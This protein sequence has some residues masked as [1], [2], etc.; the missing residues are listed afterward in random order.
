MIQKEILKQVIEFY[1]KKTIKKDL[2]KRDVKINLNLDLITIISGI[3]R[4]GKSTLLQTELKTIKNLIYLN[5]EDPRLNKFTIE[6]FMK[7]EELFPNTNTYFFDE[8]Q[9]IENW[10]QYIRFA[11]DSNK[12]IFLTGSNASMLSRELGTKLTGRYKNIELF[13]FN[14]N[15]F[16]KIKKTKPSIDS[17]KEFLIKGG[18]PEFLKTDDIEYLQTLFNNILSRDIIV[19]RDIKNDKQIKELALFLLSNVGKEFSFNKTSKLLGIKSVRTIIDYTNY[20]KESYLIELIPN[21]SPS[22]KKQIINPKKAYAIDLGMINANTLSLSD[23]SGRKL[24]NVI[25][26]HLRQKYKKIFYFKEE[27]ECDF[28]CEDKA[29]QVCLKLNEDNLNREMNGLKEALKK[30][31]AKEGII[32]TLNQEDNLNKIK[33]IPAWK[34]LLN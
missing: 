32:I 28:I 29:F 21:Y 8:I 10:E 20:L 16:L 30:T 17:F 5:F 27:N 13:P 6:D 19:R 2:I 22:I 1:K 15:E 14:Y 18:F 3:R 34:F 7:I 12:R 24:E 33:V 11:H 4:C 9:N 23:D 25:Y 26:L 31:K